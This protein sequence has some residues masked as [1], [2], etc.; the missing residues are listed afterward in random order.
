ML[1]EVYFGEVSEKGKLTGDS[2]LALLL[3]GHDWRQWHCEVMERCQSEHPE[4]R[5]FDRWFLIA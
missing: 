1:V 5:P 3:V 4:P 2:V